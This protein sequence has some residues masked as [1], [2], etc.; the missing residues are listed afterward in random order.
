MET[1]KVEVVV[2]K[3]PTGPVDKSKSHKTVQSRPAA[4]EG[5][6]GREYVHR[7]VECPWCN[8]WSW[9]WYDTDAYHSYTCCYCGND[10]T[11]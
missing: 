4:S 9:I 10:F 1:K 2:G 3:K 6:G 8:G 5:T 7:L 11:I